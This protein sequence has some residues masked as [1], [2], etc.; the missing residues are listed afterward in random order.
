MGQVAKNEVASGDL[1]KLEALLKEHDIDALITKHKPQDLSIGFDAEWLDDEALAASFPRMNSA[2]PYF[3]TLSPL[4]IKYGLTDR[5]AFSTI[6][7]HELGHI[8]DRT[9][10]WTRYT[11]LDEE[12]RDVLEYEAD[13]FVVAC[14]WKDSLIETL[15][16]AIVL[17]PEH[18][19]SEGMA[20]K[21]L[22]RYCVTA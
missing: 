4:L 7:L 6:I 21:R 1:E 12:N 20:R 13:D 16:R 10:N 15:Q 19:A 22:S 9:R 2:K 17:G 8:I 11:S 5:E 3:I 14:G 18:R